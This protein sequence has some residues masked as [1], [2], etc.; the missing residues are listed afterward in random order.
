MWGGTVG[1]NSSNTDYNAD[2]S[3]DSDDEEETIVH[4]RM[5]PYTLIV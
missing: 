3:E 4:D 5:P 1:T 2:V